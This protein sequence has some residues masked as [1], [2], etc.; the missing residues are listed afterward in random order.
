[1]I[2]DHV[3]FWVPASSYCQRAVDLQRVVDCWR[4]GELNRQR[5]CDLKAESIIAFPRNGLYERSYCYSLSLS[6]F[7]VKA[8]CI[9]TIDGR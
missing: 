1:M 8:S 9:M 5:M 7:H 2:N 3:I 6:L 4:V